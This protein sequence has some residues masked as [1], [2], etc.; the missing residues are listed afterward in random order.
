MQGRSSVR[1][2]LVGTVIVAA[3]IG[4]FILLGVAGGGPGF[5]ASRQTIDVVFR[6]GQGI[7]VG[8]PVRIAGLDAGRVVDIDLVEIEGTLMARVKL[9]LPTHLAKKLR[10]DAKIT[11]QASL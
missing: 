6:D 2:L 8:N 5:L 10:Q 3:L 4:L 9:S 7:R 1:E 11:V